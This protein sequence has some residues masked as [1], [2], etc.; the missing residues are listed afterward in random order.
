MKLNPYAIGDR[1]VATRD[2][3][4]SGLYAHVGDV[5]VVRRVGSGPYPINVAHERDNVLAKSF[6]VMFDEI[7]L[8]EPLPEEP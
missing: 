6:C 7:R 8:A 2:I 4:P 5:L 1:V 3:G